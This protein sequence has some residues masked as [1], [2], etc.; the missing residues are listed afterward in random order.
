VVDVSG[1][2]VSAAGVSGAAAPPVIAMWAHPRAVSTAFLRMMIERGDVTVV[3]EPLVTLADFGK[4]E[5]AAPDGGTVELTAIA[6]VLAQL[7]ALG[8]SRPVFSKDTLEYRYAHLYEHPE[9]HADFRHVFMVRDPAKAIASHFAMKPTVALS[10][11]GYEHQSELFDLV[12][13]TAAGPPLVISAERLVEDPAGVVSAFCD[14]VGLPYRP[15]ALRWEPQDRAEW[16]LTRQ[17]HVDATASA[18]FEAPEKHYADTVE[19]NDLLRS[20][21]AYHRPFYDHMIQYAL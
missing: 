7:R 14:E 19:N 1:A 15:E 12:R 8:A 6:D 20:Y 9:E 18:G 17:W 3:H 10:E 11:I 4:V 13:A 2:G 5:M 21:D 16:R